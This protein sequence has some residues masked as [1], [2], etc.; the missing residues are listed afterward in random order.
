MREA[1]RADLAAIGLVGAVRDQIDPEL[2]LGRL[3]HGVDLAFGGAE[4]FGIELEVMDQGFHRHL[5]LGPARRCDLVVGGH[6]RPTDLAQLFAGL[7]DDLRRFPH[8]LHPAEITV[9]AV[10]VLAQRNLEVEVVVALVRL[11]ATQVP[12]DAG[13]SHHHAG[14]APG[15]GLFLADH[16]NIDVPLLEDAVAGDQAFDVVTDRREAL[17]PA[18]DVLDQLIGQ[19]LVDAARPEIVGMQTSA[20][21][22]LVEDHQL[23]AFL[24]APQRR[25]QGSDIH[26]LCRNVQQMVEDATNLGIEHPDEAAPDRHLDA[27]KFFDGQAEGM[28]LVHRR[29]IVEPVE[30]RHVL[31]V[32]P[33]LHQLFGPAMQQPD[34][35]IDPFDDFAVK[36]QHKAQN[37][38]GGR[39]LRTKVDVEL[40]DRRFGDH[41]QVR[42]VVSHQKTPWVVGFNILAEIISTLS[43]GRR[44]G[45]SSPLPRGSG[46]QRPGIRRS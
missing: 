31:K 9:I 12:G 17:G 14:E 41:G 21:G 6:D 1:R 3:D 33:G 38:V 5:H 18:V 10:A 40:T 25:R 11:V 8:L 46:S 26:G 19:V 7:A 15:Q 22:A 29:H 34:M 30:I 32:G 43:S 23:F 2:A 24:E 37:A 16:T 28:F 20:T 36:F 4:A 39:M 35:G 45:H 42:G 27:Q 44:A 13:P